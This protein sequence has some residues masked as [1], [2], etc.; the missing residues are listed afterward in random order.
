MGERKR[1]SMAYEAGS[2]AAVLALVAACAAATAWAQAPACAGPAC[3]RAP[4]VKEADA[5]CRIDDVDGTT[6]PARQFES[7]CLAKRRFAAPQRAAA[8]REDGPDCGATAA[9]DVIESLTVYGTREAEDVY[10]P[11]LE[12]RFAGVL[13]RGNPEVNGG[14][15]RHGAFHALGMYWGADPLSFLYLNI[16]YGL[17]E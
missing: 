9:D 14:K 5:P 13:V 11:T 7:G 12:Q 17:F 16:R 4:A 8:C 2:L 6:P 15:I 10:A 1:A 3:S